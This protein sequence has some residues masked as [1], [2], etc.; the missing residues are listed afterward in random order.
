[1]NLN[2]PPISPLRN[3]PVLAPTDPTPKTKAI[4]NNNNI[5]PKEKKNRKEAKAR[6]SSHRTPDLYLAFFVHQL[7]PA[8]V[9]YFKLTGS[10]LPGHPK[11]RI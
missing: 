10:K 8:E 7:P 11:E 6:K 3:L 9:E 5:K 4:N 1:M 2:H